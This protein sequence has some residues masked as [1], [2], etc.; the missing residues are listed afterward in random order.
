[1]AVDTRSATKGVVFRS[2]PEGEIQVTDLQLDS[3][4]V[5]QPQDLERGEVLVDNLYVSLDPYLRG[6]MRRSQV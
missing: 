1:M 6:R 3:L 4:V 5:K 2:I